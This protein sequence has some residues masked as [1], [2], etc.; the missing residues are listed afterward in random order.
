MEEPYIYL[1]KLAKEDLK[2]GVAITFEQFRDRFRESGLTS[3]PLSIYQKI[4]ATTTP[5]ASNDMGMDAYMALLDYQELQH[6]FKES[7]EARKEAKKAM[8]AAVI[9]IVVQI[10]LWGADKIWSQPP[11]NF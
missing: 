8:W 3:N 5:H 1:L 7:K 10:V 6:A 4:Y 11:P 2:N 9:A